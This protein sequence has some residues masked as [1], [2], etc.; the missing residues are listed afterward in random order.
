VLS[1]LFRRL[2]LEGLDALHKAGRLTFLGDLAPPA[3]KRAFDAALAP[4]RV[5]IRHPLFD[6]IRPTR[7]HVPISPHGGLYE[8]PSLCGSA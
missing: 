5:P 8:T 7:G 6:P 1:R 2:F 4:L 3:D